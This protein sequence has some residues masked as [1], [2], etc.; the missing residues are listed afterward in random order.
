MSVQGD[1]V[2]KRPEMIDAEWHTRIKR[3]KTA[4]EQGRLAHEHAHNGSAATMFPARGVIRRTDQ[5]RASAMPTFPAHGDDPPT[6]WPGSFTP[7]HVPR[8]RG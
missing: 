6:P 4:R 1:E 2:L 8:A 3:A 7:R 5:C